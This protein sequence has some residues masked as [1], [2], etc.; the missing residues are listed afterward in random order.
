MANISCSTPNALKVDLKTLQLSITAHWTAMQQATPM[1]VLPKKVCCPII[2]TAGTSEKWAYFEQRWSDYKQA[3][4]L[5]GNGVIF[6][7]LDYCDETLRKDL[8]WMFSM[9]ASMMSVHDALVHGLEDKE[10]R[11]DIL[12]DSK[13]DLTLEEALS[14]DANHFRYCGHHYFVAVDRYSNWPIMEKASNGAAGLIATLCCIF[15][16]YDISDEL[17]SDGGPEFTSRQMVTF[18]HNWGVHYRITSVAFPHGNCRH[19]AMCLFDHPIQDFIL[20]YPGKYQPHST[21]CETMTSQEEALRN[22]HMHAA[23]WLSEHTCLLPPVTVRDCVSIQNQV[24]PNPTKWDKIGVIIEY[25]LVVSCTPLLMAP[26]PSV[27]LTP[28]PTMRLPSQPSLTAPHA[29]TPR[30]PQAYPMCPLPNTKTTTTGN[31]S[32]SPNPRVMPIS[33]TFTTSG[34]ATNGCTPRDFQALQLHNAPGL[35]EQSVPDVADPPSCNH[36]VRRY[37]RLAKTDIKA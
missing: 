15:M 35:R 13:Q 3:T 20:T 25:L 4:R 9:L 16:T 7:L 26:G 37:T 6:Q 19:R 17:T 30:T 11:H 10:I 36:P 12:G 27:S 34:H 2:S 31:P 24:G 29:A 18:L 33:P 8:T 28:T 32:T 14:L 1:K 21:W 5:M 22:H 23:K